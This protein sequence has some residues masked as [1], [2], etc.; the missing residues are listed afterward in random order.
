MVVSHLWFSAKKV[1]NAKVMIHGMVTK[2]RIYI[3]MELLLP[4]RVCLL[5]SVV[6]NECGLAANYLR[7][8]G[9]AACWLGLEQTG[10]R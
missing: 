4:R 7:S 10:A 1:S 2:M 8:R 5:D 6:F 3:F 9:L